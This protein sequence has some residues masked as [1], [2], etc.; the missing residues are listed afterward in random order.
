MSSDVIGRIETFKQLVNTLS[1][2]IHTA[3]PPEIERQVF[4]HS[5]PLIQSV[6]WLMT[7]FHKDLTA[8]MSVDDTV[9][10]LMTWRGDIARLLA[11]NEV[12]F[13][14]MVR[15]NEIWGYM[16]DYQSGISIGHSLTKKDELFLDKLM[17]K[18]LYIA[19]VWLN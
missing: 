7:G 3:I 13:D 10:H 15:D 16:S 4:T 6:A 18:D 17:L 1:Q 12:S 11:D 14:I 2:Y 8:D 9:N 5:A 19:P